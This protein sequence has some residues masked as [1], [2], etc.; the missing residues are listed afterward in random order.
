MTQLAVFVT[1][2]FGCVFRLN[3]CWAVPAISNE[4]LEPLVWQA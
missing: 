3:V 2:S 4:T 1:F